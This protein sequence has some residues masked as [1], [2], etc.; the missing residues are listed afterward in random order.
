MNREEN[1]R[2]MLDE[3][4]KEPVAV[5]FI[6]DLLRFCELVDDVADGDRE[7]RPEGCAELLR[8]A[9][10]NLP[11][12]P[13]FANFRDQLLGAIQISIDAWT[14][15]TELE[16]GVTEIS[17]STCI[18]HLDALRCSFELRNT[19]FGV[20]PLCVELLHGHDAGETFSRVWLKLTREYES[21]EHYTAKV[22]A[23]TRPRKED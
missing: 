21:F 8:I 18:R 11:A 20:A 23:T 3:H 17:T 22:T 13:F 5:A 7:V 2:N 19:I 16:I 12:N 4:V 15:A 6:Q 9:L 10:V 1:I 14:R